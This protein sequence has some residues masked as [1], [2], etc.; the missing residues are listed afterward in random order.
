MTMN[1]EMIMMQQARRPL[2]PLKLAK[3]VWTA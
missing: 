2:K 3:D 1:Q